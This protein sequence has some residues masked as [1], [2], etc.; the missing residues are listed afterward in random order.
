[1][2]PYLQSPC[3]PQRSSVTSALGGLA[4]QWQTPQ[5]LAQLQHFAQQL[6]QECAE[7]MALLQSP[8]VSSPNQSLTYPNNS[9]CS[10]SADGSTSSSGGAG[11]SSRILFN[12][13]EPPSHYV[14]SLERSNSNLE[15]LSSNLFDGFDVS[16]FDEAE[17]SFHS[18]ILSDDVTFHSDADQVIAMSPAAEVEVLAMSGE[19]DSPTIDRCDSTSH[20]NSDLCSDQG[21]NVPSPDAAELSHSTPLL[22]QKDGTGHSEPCSSKATSTLKKDGIH[23]PCAC[24]RLFG[25]RHQ[26]S[27][28][29]KEGEEGEGHAMANLGARLKLKTSLRKHVTP[30]RLHPP[31]RQPSHLA[32]SCVSPRHGGTGDTIIGEMAATGEETEVAPSWGE[33]GFPTKISLPLNRFDMRSNLQ[34]MHVDKPLHGGDASSC[35]YQAQPNNPT[36]LSYMFHDPTDLGQMYWNDSDITSPPLDALTEEELKELQKDLFNDDFS[37]V[38]DKTDSSTGKEEEE[39]GVLSQGH[40]DC[41]KKLSRDVLL[42]AYSPLMDPNASSLIDDTLNMSKGTGCEH[43][44]EDDVEGIKKITDELQRGAA[45]CGLGEQPTISEKPHSI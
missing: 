41:E 1:M 43:A 15:D 33:P 3:T 36:S 25:S 32:K 35:G 31:Y 2:P 16:N 39:E 10:R 21:A 42:K 13:D 30:K 40:L 23:R 34:P 8:S 28:N 27:S 29:E 44:M 12:V 11:A 7:R 9:H 17:S 45:L 6:Q 38:F 14:S 20:V 18:F 22:D 19:G 37:V 5:Q 24:K 4:G 26:S